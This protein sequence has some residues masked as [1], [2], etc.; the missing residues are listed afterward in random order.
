MKASGR[1]GKFGVE[2][3]GRGEGSS[4]SRPPPAHPTPQPLLTSQAWET[5]P[6]VGLPL[7]GLST[8]RLAHLMPTGPG[9][10]TRLPWAA[11]LGNACLPSHW[12]FR[13][14]GSL[15]VAKSRNRP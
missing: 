9:L 4:I 2:E 1:K 11:P 12:S 6:S 3:E 13:A 8:A 14:Q 15:C 5:A 7:P 10:P